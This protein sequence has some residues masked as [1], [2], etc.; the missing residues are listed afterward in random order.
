[1]SGIDPVN[2]GA[3]DLSSAWLRTLKAVRALPD[4]HAFH[5]VTRI[6][7]PTVENPRIRTAADAL[8]AQRDL[9]PVVTVANTIFPAGMAAT[10]ATPA[11]LVKRY[12]AALPTLR[13]LHHDNQR[14]TYF[15]RIVAYDAPSGPVDQLDNLIRKLRSERSNRSPKTARYEIGL[16]EPNDGTD[17]ALESGG[18]VQ[19]YAP[20]RDNAIMGFP[21]LSFLSFQLDGDRLHLVGQ[22]RSQRLVQRGYGNY[23]GLAGL[24][25]YVAEQVGL[26]AGELMIMAGRVEADITKRRLKELVDSLV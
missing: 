17:T 21:C 22:Y 2:M 18:V 24:Q 4:G 10:S 20:G 14:G 16:D 19:V 5:S 8:L 6:A 15:G 7:D 12:R 13:Q 3:K 11:A 26:V 23:L 1:M 9:D 25:A